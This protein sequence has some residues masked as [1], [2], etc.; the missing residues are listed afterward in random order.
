MCRIMFKMNWVYCI[1]FFKTLFRKK[2]LV[3]FQ[4]KFVCSSFK[5]A[6]RFFFFFWIGLCVDLMRSFRF[7]LG[8]NPAHAGLNRW[9]C[10][11]F[12]C[13]GNSE[14]KEYKN[15]SVRNWKSVRKLDIRDFGVYVMKVL[16]YMYFHLKNIWVF[17]EISG[18]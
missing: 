18:T 4:F 15:I 12:G 8:Y 6:R 3:S 7:R 1:L 5:W 11:L 9:I 16:L 13:V 14:V 2:I 17:F 10:L